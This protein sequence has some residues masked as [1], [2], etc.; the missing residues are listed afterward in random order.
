MANGDYPRPDARVHFGVFYPA[1]GSV[2][3]GQPESGDQVSF[4]S[5]ATMAQTA[6]R[7]LFDAFF[8]GDGQRVREHL[9]GFNTHD[10]AGRPDAITVLT[11]LAAV[12]S[13]IGL[14]ATQNATYNDPIDLARRLSTLDLLSGGRAAWNIVT[15]DNAWTGENF[16]RGG[17]LPHDQR[18]AHAE[19]HV[20]AIKAIWDGW[21]DE[22]FRT[23]GPDVWSAPVP[24]VHYADEF[25]D[26]TVHPLVPPSPQGQP[27][28][29]Q[30]GDSDGGRDLAARQAEV[31]FSR[32]AEFEEARAF[33][34]DIGRRL[35]REGR[36][37][38]DIVILPGASIIV[39]RTSAEAEQKAEW[40]RQQTVTP[41]AALAFIEKGW[42]RDLS[43]YD[44]DGPLPEIDPVIDEVSVSGGTVGHNLT[45][46]Q[47][48][49]GW[50]DLAEANEYTIRQL[51]LHFTKSRGF[52]G[53]AGEVADQLAHYVRSGVV[54]GFNLH[55]YLVPHG[56]DDIVDLLVPALQDR[57]VYPTEYAGATLREH[58]G[59]RPPL[60]RRTL[61][62]VAAEAS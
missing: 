54:G 15:T 59:L 2:V 6:E 50:R 7:G 44:V 29:F 28:L 61:A 53:S 35:V 55:P 19:A 26:L 32:H 36:P 43:E 13:R 14:A 1:I 52:V 24:P 10:V 4:A 34:E 16:R 62:P 45:P 47:L 30:A 17:Y 11:A 8:V 49:A 21:P 58:L 31:I 41:R 42:G 22:A 9:D 39:G 23:Q 12:T 48:V 33:A 38:D 20:R 5:Y 37:A 57:G 60:S 3:W 51:V 27:V 46:A 25:Y 40:I 18:Y 56:L